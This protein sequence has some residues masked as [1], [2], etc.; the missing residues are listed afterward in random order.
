MKLEIDFAIEILEAIEESDRA[1]LDIGSRILG[2]EHSTDE[3]YSYHCLM[4]AKAGLIQIWEPRDS[5]EL[6][7]AGYS[8]VDRENAIAVDIA[9]GNNHV[10]I[11]RPKMLT[12]EGHEFLDTLREKENRNGMLTFLKDNGL[13]WTISIAKECLG[14]FIKQQVGS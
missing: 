4:L 11:A 6:T 13:P 3:K 10:I 8:Y 1:V 9:S 14:A 2:G 7:D 5:D 12:F